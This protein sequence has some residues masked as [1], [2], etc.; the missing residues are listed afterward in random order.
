[1][2][3]EL[4]SLAPFLQGYKSFALIAFIVISQYSDRLETWSGNLS[5]I[6]S[7]TDLDSDRETNN[8]SNILVI[9]INML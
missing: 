5:D 6:I 8:E 7:L 4:I 3:S 9:Y 1:M 2:D